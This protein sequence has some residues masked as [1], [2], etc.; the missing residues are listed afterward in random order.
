MKRS[1]ALVISVSLLLSAAHRAGADE[2]APSVPLY[3]DLGKHHHA[4]TTQSPQAQ[5]YFDQGLRL[6]YAFNHAEAIAAFKEAARIDPDCAMCYW[7]AALAMGPN[8]NLPMDLKDEPAAHELAQKAL[9][10]AQKVSEPERAYIEA[11]AKRYGNEP[12]DSRSARDFAYADAMRRVAKRHKND[13]DA[14]T[15]FAEA[16]MD[17]QPWDYWT[18][19]GAPKGHIEEIVA[20]LERVIKANPNHPGACHFYIH[21]VEASMH[22][23]RALPCAKRLAGLMPGAGHLVHMPAHT[24]M[25]VGMYQEAEE[26]NVHAVHVDEGYIRDRKP[27]GFY[28]MAYYPHNL[29]FLYW[30][31]AMAGRSQVAIATA[32]ELATKVPDEMVKEVPPL[33]MFKPIPYFALTLFGKW[34]DMLNEPEPAA[35]LKYTAGIWRYARGRALTATAKID[36]AKAEL[37]AVT[38]LADEIPPDQMVN[39]NSAK[40]ILQLAGKVLAGEIAAK[41]GRTDD[42]VQSLTEAIAIEDRLVYDE[43]RPWYQPVRQ[44]LGA[45]LLA[46]KRPAEADKVYREDLTRNPN[47]GWSLYG[48]TQSLKARGNKKLAALEEKYFQKAWSRADV[49]L[50]ASRF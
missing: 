16:L 25:R 48:L 27:Q 28:P 32:R 11:L 14:A 23:Q 49:T 13:Q 43:P 33:E 30:A 35:E 36:E 10:L 21:A 26:A 39:L 9:A 38:K 4:I 31:S 18:A 3:D 1:I 15:L 47:N 29:H 40:S 20:T 50:T 44:N 17:L 6:T 37:G 12:G 42:A 2:T 7:G 19:N 5:G 24:Y 41:E 22:P 34:D 46:A 8:I 45:V